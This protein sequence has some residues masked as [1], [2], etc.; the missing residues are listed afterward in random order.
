VVK[1]E[2]LEPLTTYYYKA[3]SSNGIVTSESQIYSVTTA[4]TNP[5]LGEIN[6]YFNQAV[7]NSVA[8]PG[9]EA[10]GNI[11]LRD[12]V[13]ERINAAT[14]SIDIA[15]YSFT[16]NDVANALI[17]AKNRGVK[18]R[19]VYHNRDVQSAIQQLLDEGIEMSQRSSSGLMHNKFAVFDARDDSSENDW[20]WTGSWNWTTL[21]MD[22]RN[23][24]V[25]INDHAL[26]Q[27]YTTEFEEMWGSEGDEPNPD[28]AKFGAQKTDNTTHSFNIGG[29]P[30][31]LY[32]SPSD[33]TEDYIENA[34]ASADTSIYFALLVFTSNGLYSTIEDRHSAGVE[35]IRGIINN[36][37][38][39]G[40]EYTNLKNLSNSEIFSFGGSRTL[41]NKYG[42]V[43]A[44]FK[45][46]KP[47]TITG[48]HNWSASANER[49]D[50]NTLIIDDIY[51]A[52]QYMQE[53]KKVYNESGG[54]TS[55]V[56]PVITDVK[57]K[58][59]YPESI[60]LNQNYPNPFNP[61][62]TITF[63][64]PKRNFVDLSVYN[65]LGQKVL[66]IYEGEADAG[67]NVF[68]FNANDVPGGL[69]SGMYIYRLSTDKK[70]LTKKFILLK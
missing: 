59:L 58:G 16:L 61:L 42:L 25:E 44:P 68:D 65:M 11:D 57:E 60:V 20:V 22:W 63:F 9:N 3:Y 50:E 49:N 17:A 48:S 35:D 67:L 4:S 46:S 32:F 43:D 34:V 36:I 27:A 54:T 19:V 12:K 47:T 56:V 6:V 7:D 18:V 8:I 1:I 15:L 55:F 69:S 28:E 14:H 40:S 5:E 24:V 62:T 30:I 26:A 38:S 10:K 45:T 64:L 21:E 52:N 2:D 53:F 66:T 39:T 29:N 70:A 33:N 41:H 31:K 37:N 23:N 13:I 51:I